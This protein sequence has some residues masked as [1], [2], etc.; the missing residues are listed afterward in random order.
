M[1]TSAPDLLGPASLALYRRLSGDAT[2]RGLLGVAVAAP[3]TEN[4]VYD[5]WAPEDAPDRYVTVSDLIETPYNTHGAWGADVVATLHVWTRGV[6]SWTPGLG[7]AARI[8]TLLDHQPLPLVDA[9]GLVVT[10]VRHEQTLTLGDPDPE[11]RHLPVR[12]RITI[13]QET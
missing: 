4:G 6:R 5:S 10:A 8:K 3:D 13:E 1:S 11:V 2:L 12:I 9:P 7:I